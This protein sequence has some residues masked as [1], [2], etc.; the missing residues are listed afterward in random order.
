VVEVVAVELVDRDPQA[1]RAMKELKF[2]SSKKQVTE[3]GVW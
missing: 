2:L 1:A 3:E